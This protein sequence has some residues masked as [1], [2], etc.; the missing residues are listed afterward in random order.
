MVCEKAGW[1]KEAFHVI[2]LSIIYVLLANAR[3]APENKYG[4]PDE[5]ISVTIV[6]PIIAGIILSC[7]TGYLTGLF[8][9]VMEAMSPA[10]TVSNFVSIIPQMLMGYVAGRF[11]NKV[12]SPIIALSLGIGYLLNTAMLMLTGFIDYRLIF[13]WN[14]ILGMAYEI[15]VDV[16]TIIVIVTIYRLGFENESDY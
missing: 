12:P 8:G 9:P 7:R 10:G 4:L 3:T 16:I 1:K 14:F 15:I 13:E 6:I 2:I 11:R 5:M